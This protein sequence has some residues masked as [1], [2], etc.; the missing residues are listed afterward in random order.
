MDVRTWLE[1]HGLGQYAEG[2]ASNDVDT[3]V[4]RTLT[5]D[6]LKELGVASLGHRKKLLAAI[7]E[8]TGRGRRGRRRSAPRRQE[9]IPRGTWPS[10][11]SRLRGC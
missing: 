9:P 4:L 1:H 5:A 10:A 2:F 8:L 3:E 7:A 6:D 11:S